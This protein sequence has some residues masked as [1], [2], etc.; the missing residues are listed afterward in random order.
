MIKKMLF[1]LSVLILNSGNSQSQESIYNKEFLDS[2]FNEYI[3]L[4]E[5]LRDQEYEKLTSS[6][7]GNN[8]CGFSV[9]TFV[10]QNLNLFTPQQ[11]EVINKFLG[12]PTSPFSIVS[13]SGK[14]RIHYDTTST[15]KPKYNSS[16]NV[17]ENLAMVDKAI[18]SA[19][20]FEVKY[21]GYPPPPS[22][23]GSGGDN[24]Y[25]IYITNLGDYGYTDPESD[26][27]ND[28]YTSFMV[29]DNDYVGF[30]ST[31]I[32][33]LQVTLAHEFH[34]AIQ[35][36]NYILRWADV[37]FYEITSTSMEEFVFDDVNDYYAYMPS[38]FLSPQRAFSENDGYNL[39][40]WNI[41]LKDNFDFNIIKRQW[42]LMPNQRALDAINTS[43]SERSSNFKHELNNFG[44]WT[45]Y[46][47]YRAVSSK[48][49]E[50]ASQYPLIRPLYTIAFTSPSDII[51]INSK[52]TANNF[53]R[54]TNQDYNND[55][56]F[57]L[58]TNGDVQTAVINNNQTDSIT[59][60]LYD[61]PENGANKVD[62][63]YY[64]KFTTKNPFLWAVSEISDTTINVIEPQPETDY[65]YP[66]PFSYN[67]YLAGKIYIPV[68]ANNT[69]TA[70]LY[71]FNM[72]MELIYS[73]DE[74]Q[75]D[76]LNKNVI[77]WTVKDNNDEKLASGVYFYVVKSGDDVKK[78]KL[79]ILHD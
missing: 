26:L 42:E 62:S 71:V 27:G 12:R 10:R 17:E 4:K 63:A 70:G 60:Y 46:T 1:V 79:V 54:I 20:N 69:S 41:Y 13:S 2:L 34:H 8:K 73:N 5:P 19:Y 32:Y 16:L 28:K 47:N 57:V 76:K 43:L 22:D 25:D 55:T 77:S 74:V 23:N 48:F 72:A 18:D 58:I 52:P 33:G 49:F 56:L 29:I 75:I 9:I 68:S 59:Y 36:G 24:L 40:I 66:M 3:K 7:P 14:F 35:M 78:G 64:S 21:L 61:Y 31:G 11:Q 44:V 67:K 37:F 65:P 50:E 6:V 38:Y 15:V 53:I 30:Y 45:Y 51:T 39:T